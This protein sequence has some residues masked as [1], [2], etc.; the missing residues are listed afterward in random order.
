MTRHLLTWTSLSAVS[1]YGFGCE[2]TVSKQ[3]KT[4]IQALRAELESLRHELNATNA[5]AQ[6]YQAS[7]LAWE[8]D[9]SAIWTI[10]TRNQNRVEDLEMAGLVTEEWV[11]SAIATGTGSLGELA[12]RI[13]AWMMPH[14]R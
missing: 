9:V 4:E 14:P 7:A 10:V 3:D 13:E 12:T 6:E 1:P 2:D 5:S 11:S 8:D